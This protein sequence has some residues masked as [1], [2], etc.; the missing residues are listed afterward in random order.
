MSLI[1]VLAIVLAVAGT[2]ATVADAD[3]TGLVTLKTA[4][5]S[6]GLQAVGKLMLGDRGFCTGTLIE[7]R[8]VLT[9]AHCLFDRETGGRLDIAEIQFLA[10]WRYG[11]AAAY[12]GVRRALPHPDYV[13]GGGD[14]V[15]R[16]GV[17]LALLELDQ[18][19]RNA[20]IPPIAT[21]V[22]PLEGDQVGV[23]SYAQ[24]RAEAPSLQ[25]TCDVLAIRPE[26]LVL[27]CSVDF[28]SSGAPVFALDEG[29]PRVISVVSAKA[30]VEGRKVSLAVPM[31]EPLAELRAMLEND[32][33]EVGKRVTGVRTLSA[34]EGRFPKP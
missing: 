19:I 17:D 29:S 28:G 30:E 32:A 22:D 21:D 33:G 10:G 6:R 14:R 27:S 7:P 1:K 15:E 9:A 24:D 34:G 12:R 26:V 8:L 25:E 2:G 3:E 13:Y 20:A 11:R 31:Q 23:V 18:P 4:D 5:D 16:V